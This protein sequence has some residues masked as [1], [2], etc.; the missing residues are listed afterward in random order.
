M[1]QDTDY[2]D[3]IHDIKSKIRQSQYEA[4]KAVNKELL[5]L[6]WYIGRQIVQK[7]SEL[8]WGKSVVEQIAKDLQTEFVGISGFSAR[9]LWLMKQFYELYSTNEIL[10]PLVAEIG[11]SHHLQ[12]MAK[13]KDDLQREF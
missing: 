2:Q 9:N 1:T 4:M 8:G 13:C 6:Y 10:Q 12:I 7:Q 3:F 11:W 5:L